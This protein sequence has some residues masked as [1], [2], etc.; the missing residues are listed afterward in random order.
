MTSNL[1]K[2]SI[3]NFTTISL[4]EL[5]FEPKGQVFVVS[6]DN[7]SGKTSVLDAIEIALAGKSAKKVADPVKNGATTT[8]II[9]EFD[10]VT[11]KRVIT[12]KSNTIEI[13][14]NS[15]GQKIDN[16]L[17]QVWKRVAVDP[18]AFAAMDE[19]AQV[20]TLLEL[21]GYDVAKDNAE[22]KSHYTDR[23][24]AKR[25]LDRAKAYADGLPNVPADTPDEE[26]SAGDILATLNKAIAFNTSI[27]E[28][29]AEYNR[30]AGLIAHNKTRV[31]ALLVEIR[32]LQD[33]IAA[34][35]LLQKDDEET[36]STVQLIDT[37]KYTE[38]IA[39]LDTV[40]ANVRAKLAKQAALKEQVARE[41]GWAA[42]DAKVKAVL[43]RKRK[44]LTAGNLPAGLTI[45]PETE[46]L[47]L[48]GAPFDGASSGEKVMTGYQIGREL[49]P[50]LKLV[51][52]R[53]GSLLDETNSA[54]IAGWA[55]TDGVLVVM[56]NVHGSANGVRLVDGAAV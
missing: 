6:G 31:D 41:A 19:K 42:L 39:N 52:I 33:G 7:G 27:D 43:E 10:D 26:Q 21:I 20:A 34:D 35:E 37:S 1:I 17:E 38:Q 15:D 32:E 46:T 11:V 30:R 29:Q 49:N 55:E 18:F 28:V 51:L 36:L 4:L 48:N 3:E 40:N 24:D 54:L 25:E 47:L 44:A 9:L 2:A 22:Y 8:R 5:T 53:D 23:T 56:E 13:R 14:R 12:A 50:D 45:D 16:E